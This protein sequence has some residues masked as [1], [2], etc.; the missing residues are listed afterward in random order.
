MFIRS[1]FFLRRDRPLGAMIGL[2]TLCNVYE[3][4]VVG[5]LTQKLATLPMV[6]TTHILSVT[7]IARVIRRIK[8]LFGPDEGFATAFLELKLF[9]RLFIG[10][11]V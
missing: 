7:V 3:A 8:S 11:K 6:Y 4:K 2:V 1:L 5:H 9:N 10:R